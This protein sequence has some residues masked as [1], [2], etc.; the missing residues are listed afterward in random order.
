M[1]GIHRAS[2]E[3]FHALFGGGLYVER[4]SL[5]DAH[6]QDVWKWQSCGRAAQSFLRSVLPHLVIR[7]EEAKFVLEIRRGMGTFEKRRL[8][9][10]LSLL[11]RSVA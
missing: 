6:W 7:R 4:R 8:S 9:E 10:T 5:I 3:R 11:K 2:I 1:K